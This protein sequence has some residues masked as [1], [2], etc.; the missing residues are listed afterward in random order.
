[1]T[2]RPVVEARRPLVHP[3]PTGAHDC[4]C[5]TGSVA[6]GPA[7]EGLPVLLEMIRNALA[8]PQTPRLALELAEAAAA[9]GVSTKFFN[10]H[11]RHELRLVRR[12]RR[13]LVPVREL[14]RWLEESAALT[15]GGQP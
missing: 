14:E 1:M 7:P 6:N 3:C 5:A 8:A 15:L 10:E 2:G 13:V 12:G 4:S 11:V 9:L